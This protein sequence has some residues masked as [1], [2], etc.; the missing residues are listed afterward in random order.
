MR[1]HCVDGYYCKQVPVVD[2]ILHRWMRTLAKQLRCK[3]PCEPQVEMMKEIQHPLIWKKANH[4]LVFMV[5]IVSQ[6]VQD[7]WQQP[8]DIESFKVVNDFSHQSKFMTCK[9]ASTETEDKA[10]SDFLAEIIDMQYISQYIYIY[11]P[12]WESHVTS[13]LGG[14]DDT[15]FPQFGS[16]S[17]PIVYIYIK[18]SCIFFGG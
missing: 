6:L 2:S 15:Y 16:M 9:I 1:V 14:A 3:P 4:P 11:I 10:A 13:W 5:Y 12:D 18:F 8:Y 17:L 7:F